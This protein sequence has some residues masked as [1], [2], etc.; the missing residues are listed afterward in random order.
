M[1]EMFMKKVDSPWD[2]QV[3]SNEGTVPKENVEEEIVIQTAP[4]LTDAKA[5][6]MTIPRSLVYT[7]GWRALVWQNKETGQFQDLTEEEFEAYNNGGIVTYTRETAGITGE[8]AG[9]EGDAGSSDS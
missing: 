5:K 9:T 1:G 6:L 7:I 2:L 4:L 3:V 8:D